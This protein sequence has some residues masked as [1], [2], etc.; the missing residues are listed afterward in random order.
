[1]YYM[2]ASLVHLLFAPFRKFTE[3]AF[4]IPLTSCL[5]L[6]PVRCVARNGR[7]EGGNQKKG[8]GNIEIAYS[9][10]NSYSSKTQ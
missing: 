1:M 7:G 10:V 3:D 5:K 4:I 6:G 9:I 2:S 8:L